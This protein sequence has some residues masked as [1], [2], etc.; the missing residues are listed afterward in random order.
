MAVTNGVITNGIIK[1]GFNTIGAPNIIGS[2]ILNTA[3]GAPNAAI[4]L[5]SFLFEKINI[6]ITRANVAPD[7]PKLA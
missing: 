3:I 4:V 2:L 6:A 5:V 7:P 1:V